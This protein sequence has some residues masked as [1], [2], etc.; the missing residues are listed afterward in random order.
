M[1]TPL[2]RNRIKQNHTIVDH[3]VSSIFF[4]DEL[5]DISFFRTNA[6]IKLLIVYIPS[7]SHVEPRFHHIAKSACHNA[8]LE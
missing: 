2:F 7:P 5:P 8:L 4:F 3:G 6:C 1:I